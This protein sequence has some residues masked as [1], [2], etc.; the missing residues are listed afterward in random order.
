MFPHLRSLNGICM[1]I[2]VNYSPKSTNTCA[3]FMWGIMPH[4]ILIRLDI[5]IPSC[6]AVGCP[7]SNLWC[8]QQKP[9][10]ARNSLRR[11]GF[12]ALHPWGT[13]KNPRKPPRK[14]PMVSVSPP[15]KS[16]ASGA[17]WPS[18]DWVDGKSSTDFRHQK[19]ME[20]QRDFHG[21]HTW[22]SS[23]HV[24]NPGNHP[25]VISIGDGLSIPKW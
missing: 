19:A 7:I 5:Q 18:C 1:M 24:V 6:Q 2:F 20:I 15:G 22:S 12:P 14:C 13:L 21:F 17:R 16:P 10:A 3:K 4:D 9:R 11:L 25:Q 23:R 8:R